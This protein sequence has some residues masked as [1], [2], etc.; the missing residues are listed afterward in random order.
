MAWSGCHECIDLASAEAVHTVLAGGLPIV[1][2]GHHV[3]GIGVSS[4]SGDED[5]EV[6]RAGL[7]AVGAKTAF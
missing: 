1:I 4:G 6:A 5:L 3:G 2:D 7:T